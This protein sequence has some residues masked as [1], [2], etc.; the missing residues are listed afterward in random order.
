MV[1]IRRILF[2]LAAFG[3]IAAATTA[4]AQPA[5]GVE[6][7]PKSS[8]K[9]APSDT[10]VSIEKECVGADGAEVCWLKFTDGTRCVV[11]SHAETGDSS[12]ALNC[13][14]STPL[15]RLHRMPKD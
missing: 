7:T 12:T 4:F 8:A 9:H 15:E 1:G 11:A 3:A 5:S 2:V 13:H 10:P 14:F 6:S